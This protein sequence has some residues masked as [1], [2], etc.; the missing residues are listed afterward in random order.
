MKAFI[1]KK[2]IFILLL[3]LVVIF[4]LYK[5]PFWIIFGIPCPGCGMTRAFKSLL[6]L[7]IAQAFQYHPLFFLVIILGIG[8]ILDF[9]KILHVTDSVKNMILYISCFLF[10]LVYI[11]RFIHGSDIVYLDMKK[12]LLYQV[13]QYFNP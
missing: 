11:V 10:I 8:W 13:L 9:F 3:S 4:F 5:C 2:N 1:T 7:D 12:G 6:T